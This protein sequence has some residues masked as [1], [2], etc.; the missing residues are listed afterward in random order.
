MALKNEF[1]KTKRGA[2]EN[3]ILLFIFFF[4]LVGGVSSSGWFEFLRRGLQIALLAFVVRAY[5]T[6]DQLIAITTTAGLIAIPTAFAFWHEHVTL[7]NWYH[8]FRGVPEKPAVR[9]GEVR[10]QG[11]FGHP[12]YAGVFWITFS[13]FFIWRSI[14]APTLIRKLFWVIAI[15]SALVIGF[16]TSSSTPILAFAAILLCWFAYIFR[17]Y[18]RFFLPGLC[19]TVVALHIAMKAPVWHLISR[20]GT[21]EGSTSHF[22]FQMIDAFIRNI[23]EWIIAGT[24]STAHWFWGGQDIVNQFVYFGVRGGAIT[25]ILFLTIVFVV[26]RNLSQLFEVYQAKNSPDR[27]M[28]WAFIASICSTLITFVGVSYFHQIEIQLYFILFGAMA[29]VRNT[30]TE[31]NA[32]EHRKPNS[33]YRRRFL[34]PNQPPINNSR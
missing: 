24:Q 25:L 33:D 29:L 1:P 21:A 31:A 10:A 11:P 28:I 22:R 20:V 8:I 32:H 6:K 19:L 13:C 18:R 12:I 30:P 14:I 3:L 34:G 9:F 2:P 4:I 7:E 5:L 27:W 16:S 23:D 15:G 17:N 26:I